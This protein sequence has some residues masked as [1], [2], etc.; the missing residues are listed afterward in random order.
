MAFPG[1]LVPR[2]W[3][4]VWWRQAGPR[5]SPGAALLCPYVPE[6]ATS[7]L[8][9]S[10]SP[11]SGVSYCPFHAVTTLKVTMASAFVSTELK[12]PESTS[13]RGRQPGQ[14]GEGSDLSI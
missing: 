3:A 4:L 5:P 10:G 12:K 6:G 13:P 9:L 7:F 2:L 14:G 8:Q 1:G 11:S